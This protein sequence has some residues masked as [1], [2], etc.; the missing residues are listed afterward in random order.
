MESKRFRLNTTDLRSIIIGACIAVGGALL[1]YLA[2]IVTQVD[3]GDNT[4]LIVAVL[5]II[6]NTA[7]KAI[8][9]NR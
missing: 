9:G 6:I 2:E 1:T 3:F 8:E 7:K 4:A 5:S